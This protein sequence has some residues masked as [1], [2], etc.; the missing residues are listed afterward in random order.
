MKKSAVTGKKKRLLHQR[1]TDNLETMKYYAVIDT[2]VVVS[3]QLSSRVDSPIVQ[4][5]DLIM[6]GEIILMFNED[7]LE[8]YEQECSP[9]TILIL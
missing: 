5:W 8:E 9:E 6:N 3:A 4:I 1:K 7:I 2:N